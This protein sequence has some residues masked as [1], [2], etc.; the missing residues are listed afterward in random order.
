[1][2]THESFMGIELGK[3]TIDDFVEYMLGVL[4]DA[5]QGVLPA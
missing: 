2:R 5:G 3:G 1:M 4:A